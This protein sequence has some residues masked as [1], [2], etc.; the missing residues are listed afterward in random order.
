MTL[1]QNFVHKVVWL[2]VEFPN[3]HGPDS[4]T[5]GGTTIGVG[6]DHVLTAL[7]C[8]SVDDIMLAHPITANNN[9]GEIE[10]RSSLI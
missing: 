6:H 7:A 8:A 1:S 4:P 5:S 3:N 9:S 2:A 10:C